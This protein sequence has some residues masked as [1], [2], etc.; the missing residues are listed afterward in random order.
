MLYRSAEKPIFDGEKSRRD[1]S[2]RAGLR[3][4]MLD[5]VAYGVLGDLSSVPI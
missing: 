5:L 1:A 3:V 4:N 2:R